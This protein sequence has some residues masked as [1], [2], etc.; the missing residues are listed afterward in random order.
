VNKKLYFILFLP[1]FGFSQLKNLDTLK[2]K[3]MDEIVVSASRSEQS[4]LQT[5]NSI[6]IVKVKT[7]YKNNH[8]T[9]PET[10]MNAAGVFVQKTNHGGGS[11]ILRGLMGNQTLILIDGIRLNN[12]TFRYG[13]NQYFNTIDPF[14]IN[15]IEVLRGSGSVQYGSDALGGTIHV[16]TANPAFNQL[17]KAK[18]IGRVATQNI[19]QTLN[20]K[21]SF[22]LKKIGILASFNKRQFGDLVGGKKTGLQSPSGYDE[23]AQN[24]KSK[25]M[26]GEGILT[27]SYQNFQASKI[28]NFHKI[29]NDNFKTN[30]ID[31][32]KRKLGY[33]NYIFNFKNKNFIKF[34]L[35]A[36]L[37]STYESRKTQKNNTEK[38][39]IETDKVLTK[40][41][42][43][44]INTV[45]LSKIIGNT[46]VE[47]Y[48]DLVKSEAN[49]TIN[50]VINQK[51]GLYPNDSKYL[52]Y[53]VYSLH[54][55]QY[56]KWQFSGGIRFN[57]F[58]IAVPNEAQKTILLS[59][60]AVVANLSVLCLINTQSSTYASI[61]SGFRAPNID[62]LGTLGIVDFRYEIPT[63]DLKPEKSY[64]YELGYKLRKNRI[65][66]YS[67]I[68]YTRLNNLI[69]R[70]K[71]PN[72]MIEN[73][74][75]Y[76]KKNVEEA[77]IKGCELNFEYFLTDK[78]KFGTEITHTFGQNLTKN[79]P[80]RRIPPTFGRVDFQFIEKKYFFKS[81]VLFANSQKRLAQ[82]D[83]D[84]NRIGKNGTSKWSIFNVSSGYNFKQISFNI[85]VNNLFNTDYRIHGSG[86]NGMGRIFYLTTSLSI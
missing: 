34:E 59:P 86:I 36:S 67:S 27:F 31:L 3:L 66:F 65:T 12:S 38:V 29:L 62:D 60:K 49:E 73:Y 74:P 51:R 37:Q 44:N 72:E 39:I 20:G 64:S 68:F 9:T 57:G 69:T 79:E 58:K 75:V 84:D 4:I 22:G 71:N 19:E 82:N 16:L 54:Q 7:D 70:I 46:G 42:S 41:I 10:L 48:H 18:V 5:P 45:F 28:P 85:L 30:Q 76:Q 8:R 14:S 52:N 47:I 40:G 56:K 61:N 15:H 11:P 53:S 2:T 35:N 50:Q 23:E 43:A 6:S 81:E 77:F 25:I 78:I 80:L 83:I 33:F 21:V 17:L 1:V 55:F 26:I 32:Q 63:F 13:P 24:I